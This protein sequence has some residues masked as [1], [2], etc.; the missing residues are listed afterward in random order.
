MFSLFSMHK[1][2]TWYAGEKLLA[3]LETTEDFERPEVL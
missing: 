1:S 3:I 2:N